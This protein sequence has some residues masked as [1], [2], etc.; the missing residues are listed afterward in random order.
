MMR[1]KFDHQMQ[2]L[3]NDLIEMGAL[4]EAFRP[5]AGASPA[6][7]ATHGVDCAH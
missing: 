2:V 3:N 7:I 6:F 5:A 1:N 4:I